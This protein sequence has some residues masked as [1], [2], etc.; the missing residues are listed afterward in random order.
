MSTSEF[1]LLDQ[2]FCHSNKEKPQIAPE[3]RTLLSVLPGPPSATWDETASGRDAFANSECLLCSYLLWTVICLAFSPRSACTCILSL[4]SLDSV[5]IS[6]TALAPSPPLLSPPLP[7]RL[8]LS[9]TSGY[10][11]G[12]IVWF[13][14]LHLHVVF[15]LNYAVDGNHSHFYVGGYILTGCRSMRSLYVP[16]GCRGQRRVGVPLRNVFAGA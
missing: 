12:H 13:S 11:D 1:S 4:L 10:K 14:F 2:V 8:L 9:P 3:M 15:Y 5:S 7:T 16:G 6:Y